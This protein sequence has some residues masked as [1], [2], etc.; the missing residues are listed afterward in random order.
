MNSRSHCTM[1]ACARFSRKRMLLRRARE[2]CWC[3]TATL[4]AMAAQTATA[5]SPRESDAT[6]IRQ[7]GLEKFL[8]RE[9]HYRRKLS[10]ARVVIG[11]T[12][13]WIVETL[14]GSIARLHG[15]MSI[16]YRQNRLVPP[17]A[18]TTAGRLR[19]NRAAA[20]RTGR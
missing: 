9:V 5:Q 19:L 20:S 8:N 14:V 6:E 1:S 18:L 15:R 4:T 3:L 12:L 7:L 16:L 13:H 17:A 2:G 10:A 11:L